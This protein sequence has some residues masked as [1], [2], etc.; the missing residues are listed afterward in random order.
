MIKM[1]VNSRMNKCIDAIRELQDMVE[2]GAGLPIAK[3]KVILDRDEVLDLLNQLENNI[4]REVK[5]GRSIL[6]T[7]ERIMQEAERDASNIVR[8]AERKAK[9]LIDESEIVRQATKNAE[10]IITNATGR[11]REIFNS[12]KAY[13]DNIFKNTDDELAKMVERTRKSKQSLKNLTYMDFEN[14]RKKDS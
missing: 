13:C 5:E 4:P 12:V 2:N 1:A 9:H 6:D 11:S 10:E 8:E 3:N 7:R 14:F